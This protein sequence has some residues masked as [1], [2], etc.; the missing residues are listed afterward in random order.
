MNANRLILAYDIG[1]TSIKVGL[2][3]PHEMRVLEKVTK[4]TEVVYPQEG[5]AELELEKFWGTLVEL[6]RKLEDE[7]ADLN[8]VSAVVFSPFL[9]SV[10]PVDES[11]NPL[12][13]MM[14]WLDSRAAGLPEKLW[15][16]ILKVEGYNLF[17]LLTFLRI[18]GGAPSKTG[19]DPISKMIWVKK[20]L[21]EVYRRTFKFLDAR[22]FLINKLT[23]EFVMGPDD[24]SL[25]WLVDTRKSKPVWW[26]PLIKKYGLDM[27]KLPKILETTDVAGYVRGE[28]ARELGLR[29]GIPV[30][31]GAGDL[32]AAAV[33][34]GAI[35]ENETH[36]YLGTSDWLGAHISKRK[37]DVSHYIGSIMSGLPGKYLLV[38][39]QEIGAGALE[40]AMNIMGIPEKYDEV[41]KLIDKT[42]SGSRNLVFLPWLYGERCPIDDPY[43]RGG[44]INLKLDTDRGEILR[45]IM[46]G[47]GLNIKWAYTHFEKIVGEQ[48]EIRLAGGGSLFEIWGQI[49]SDMLN[50]RIV[51]VSEPHNVTLLGVSM[52]AMVG[53]KIYDSFS[54]A[55]EKIKLDQTYEPNKKNSE[56]YNELFKVFVNAYKKFSK[57][58]RKL[59]KLGLK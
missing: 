36:I 26:N 3:D 32:T 13:N 17:Q 29:D 44:F 5:W 2:V 42:R 37:V 6:T 54:E 25:T 23:G 39:E 45:S 27:E 7:G 48:R 52:I 1:T 57:D 51:R 49:L 46:E 11:G 20:E 4:K 22:G 55:A 16:G 47:V 58:F 34:T 12:M 35:K 9:A 24:A 10:V 15:K 59:N 8:K 31:T 38:A 30:V 43:V 40:W 28:V 53:I 18:T 19:K 41:E 33:G 21:P 50:R 14:I 56:L